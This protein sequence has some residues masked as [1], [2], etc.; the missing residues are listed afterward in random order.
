MA[1]SSFSVPFRSLCL[2]LAFLL[3]AG[4]PQ[5]HTIFATLVVPPQSQLIDLLGLAL[6]IPDRSPLPRLI[7]ATAAPRAR[8]LL[9]ESRTPGICTS[10]PTPFVHAKLRVDEFRSVLSLESVLVE[11][12]IQR[13]FFGPGWI[14]SFAKLTDR[15]DSMMSETDMN[16]TDR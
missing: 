16:F 7:A 8:S 1:A 12:C 13:S 5:G 15:K 9:S 10:S 14:R 3:H 11:E 2:Y 4:V 6:E